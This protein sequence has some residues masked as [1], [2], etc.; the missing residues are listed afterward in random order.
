MQMYKNSSYSQTNTQKEVH[1]GTVCV[2]KGEWKEAKMEGEC[3]AV[4]IHLNM[5]THMTFIWRC[6]IKVFSK[7]IVSRLLFPFIVADLLPL[8]WGDSSLVFVGVFLCLSIVFVVYV[9]AWFY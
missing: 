9:L 4:C 3:L 1:M 5:F 2:I 7:E 6:D 8:Y